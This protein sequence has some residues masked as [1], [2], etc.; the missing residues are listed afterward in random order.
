MSD[1]TMSVII[2][3]YD[4]AHLIGRA[5]ASSF[6]QLDPG[7]EVIVVDDG[8]TDNTKQ[9]VADFGERVR[10][11]RVANRG[12]GAAR[13]F[14]IEKARGDLVAFLDS[15][16]EWISHK[17]ILQKAV[18]AARKDVL[19][20]FSD[21]AVRTA[22]GVERRHAC[23]TW[24]HD[25]R[26]WCEILGPAEPFSILAELPAEKEDFA[27]Y[28]GSLYRSELTVNHIFTSTLVVRRERADAALRF[29][30]D[31]STFEDWECYGRLAKAGNCA[32]L[33]C[34]TAWQH[35]HS[36]RR[37]TDADLLTSTAARIA[38]TKRVWGSDMEFL[39]HEGE[40]YRNILNEQHR[41]RAR[42]FL[43]RGQPSNARDELAKMRR[44]PVSYRFMARLPGWAT[45]LL[46]S[47]K[48]R[49]PV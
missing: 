48:K 29:A 46:V 30:E 4:R 21:F 11:F 17:T 3:T 38:I 19:F 9:I 13:N 22:D 37:L 18:L 2:P 36:G 10:Y 12:A 14:G 8:S 25:P 31:I 1:L 15:D 49:L 44:V 39:A 35:G 26:P 20:C 43:D 40:V 5:L 7:D 23:A 6:C 34:E 42:E 28:V 32:Y 41:L 33:E 45:H 24:H 27:V 47:A 16:D